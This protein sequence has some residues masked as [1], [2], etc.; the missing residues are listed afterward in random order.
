VT[1]IEQAIAAVVYL[2]LSLLS[3]VV[4]VRKH[5]RALAK[6]YGIS[7]ARQMIQLVGYAWR[8]GVPPREYYQLRLHR[9]HWTGT[10]RHFINQPE[11][12]HL[13]RHIS[14]A[15]TVNLEDKAHFAER[16]RRCGVPIVPTIAIFHLGYAFGADGKQSPI[17]LPK[18]HLFIKPSASYSSQGVIGVKYDAA[19]DRYFD[20]TILD[21]ERTD[22]ASDRTVPKKTAPRATVDGEPP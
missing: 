4:A 20:G 12:H 5:G 13:Q 21:A 2:P 7:Q 14:P 17:E 10:G 9:H 6:E 22:R 1:R 16:A 11:L 15:D 8:L 3:I 18:R 19:T